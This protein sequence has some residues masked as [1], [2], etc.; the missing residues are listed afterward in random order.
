M[1]WPIPLQQKLALAT[2]LQASFLGVILLDRHHMD[3]FKT[4]PYQ[5]QSAKATH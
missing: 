3:P 4:R 5:L 2:L 1:T